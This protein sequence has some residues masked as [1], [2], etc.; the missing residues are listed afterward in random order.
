M[1]KYNCMRDNPLEKLSVIMANPLPNLPVLKGQSSAKVVHFKGRSHGFFSKIANP[2][3][4]L[5]Y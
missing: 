2:L 5:S 1:Y 4:K 3:A